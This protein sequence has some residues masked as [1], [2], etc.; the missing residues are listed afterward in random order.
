MIEDMTIRNSFAGDA[1]ILH[2]RGLAKFSRHFNLSPDRLGMEEIRAYQLH[3]VEEKHSW[4]H[5]NQVTC[6]LR[7]FLRHHLGAK[8]GL[9][10]DRFRQE[11]AKL[12]PVL[13]AKSSFPSSKPSP[14]CATASR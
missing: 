6:A 8:G 12:P 3:L 1:T 7:L 4:S 13:N 14:D 2:L 11:P 5:I 9:R 10:A